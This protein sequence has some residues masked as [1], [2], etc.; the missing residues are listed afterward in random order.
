EDRGYFDEENIDLTIDQGDGSANTI[1]KVMSG[2][3][4][5]GFGDVNAIIQNA[6][7][8]PAEAPVMVYMVYNR[9]PFAIMTKASGPIRTLKDLEGKTLGSPAGGAAMRM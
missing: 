9:A 5:A 4:D 7:A 2:V 3:Y 8:R 1:T 6:A